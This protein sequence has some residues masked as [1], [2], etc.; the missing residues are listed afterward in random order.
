[1][2]R[3]LNC[4]SL[5][6]AGMLNPLKRQRL[7]KFIIKEQVD[8]ICLQETHLKEPESRFLK[9]KIWGSIYHAAALTRAKGVMI[10]ISR[11]IP[12][13]LDERIED[14]GGKVPTGHFKLH[15]YDLWWGFT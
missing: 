6:V 3:V 15:Q 7:A 4:L 5:N 2:Y 9:K 14:K 11:N 8:V 10:R 1:M 13:K 12:W